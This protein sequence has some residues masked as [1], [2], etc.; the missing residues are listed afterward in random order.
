MTLMLDEGVSTSIS[1]VFKD[2]GHSVSYVWEHVARSSPDHLIAVA[3]DQLSAVVVS[4]DKDFRSLIKRGPS[5]GGKIHYAQAG[6]ISFRIPE[7][8]AE[9]RLKD[10]ISIIEQAFTV[11]QGMTDKRLIVEIM[12]SLLNI[13]Y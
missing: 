9:T 10:E 1:D 3:A 11:R 2:R 7:V 12:P 5:K 13:Y 4:W 6:R 8:G